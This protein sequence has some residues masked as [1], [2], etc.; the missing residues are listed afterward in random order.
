MVEVAIFEMQNDLQVW[1]KYFNDFVS[2]YLHMSGSPD[3]IEYE[4]LQLTLADVLN[5]HK[6]MKAVALHCYVHLYQRN[7]AKVVALLKLVTH[8]KNTLIQHKEF[9]Y[10]CDSE[11]SLYA[12]VQSCN[13]LKSNHISKYIIDNMFGALI[14]ILFYCKGKKVPLLQ[15]WYKSY[16]DLVSIVLSEFLTLTKD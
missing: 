1:Q 8:M 10:P 3:G 11:A 15:E 16:R 12:A 6:E 5:S 7:I 4:L 14:N 2:Q 9:V 13:S